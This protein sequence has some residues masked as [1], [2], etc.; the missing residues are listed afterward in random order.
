M[1]MN[2]QK[3]SEFHRVASCDESVAYFDSYGVEHNEVE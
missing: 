2:Q 3:L 1:S